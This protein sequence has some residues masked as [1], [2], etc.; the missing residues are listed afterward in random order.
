MHPIRVLHILGGIF[1]HGGTEAFIMNYYRH[2]DRSAVQFDFVVHGFD[3]GVYDDEIEEMGG[4]IFHVPIKSR[5]YLGNIKALKS[6]LG[7]GEYSIVHSHMDAMGM[8][9]LKIAQKCHIPIRIA[10]SHNTCHQTNN[11]IQFALHEH[12]RKNIT[13]Y[14][15][16]LFACSVAAGK[17]LFGDSAIKKDNFQVAKNAIAFEHFRFD[18]GKRALFREQLDVNDNFLVGHI[19]RF[20]EQKNHIFLLDIFAELL[21]QN[22]RARLALVGD[23]HLRSSIE[24]KAKKLGISDNVLLLGARQDA[25]DLINAFDVFLLPS[26]FEGLPVVLTEA[27]ANGLKCVVSDSITKEVA[28]FDTVTFV[29]LSNSPAEWAKQ[30][31]EFSTVE[32]DGETRTVARKDFTETG[33][34]VEEAARSL[35]EFYLAVG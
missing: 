17:W 27:Q 3:K 8:V 31:L 20:S 2:I 23:G 1:H 5:D 11:K 24:E 19:G 16:H 18:K 30:V 7:S 32:D 35:Q 28:F 4:K 29:P 12:A 13:K 10:H 21:K 6:I 9:V 34:D 25:S 14:A 33:Y 15:T 26:L 22:Q